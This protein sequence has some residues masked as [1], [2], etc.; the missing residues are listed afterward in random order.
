MDLYFRAYGGTDPGRRRDHNEDAYFMDEDT[1]I[2]VVADGLGGHNA[3]E[4]ASRML[5]ETVMAQSDW[6]RALVAEHL[7]EGSKDTRQRL[8]KYLSKV[9]EQ[10]NER[11]FTEAQ[12]GAGRRGMATTAVLFVPVGMDAFICH[13]GDSRLYLMREGQLFQVTEDHSLVMQLYKRGFLKEEELA[14]HPQ[15]NVILRSVGLQ[16]TVEVDAIYLDVMPGDLFLLCSDGLSD[17]VPHE[18]LEGLMRNYRGQRLVDEAIAAANRNG[19]AD[20][21]TVLV[22]QAESEEDYDDTVIMSRI[23]IHQ[24]VEFLQDI[25]LFERLTDQECLKVNRILYE[26]DYPERSMIIREG[27]FGD[28]LFI[29][30]RGSVGV[31]RGNVYLTSIGPGGHFGELGMLGSDRR[32]ASV[33]AEQDCTL[34]V[35]KRDDF[36]DLVRDDPTL[37]N[38]ILWAFLENM[39]E[40]VRDLSRRLSEER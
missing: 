3:G 27:E 12:S 29:V 37:G 6:I 30:A 28:E 1:G 7:S 24:K 19:G 11:I 31:W 13:V 22:V 33:V 21:I 25:F 32:S 26:R 10:A 8:L 15:R 14:T 5:V 18:E 40:R 39:G 34:L 35:I 36:M 20:N 9:I 16:A 17:M 4:V 38:K 23:G 2:F